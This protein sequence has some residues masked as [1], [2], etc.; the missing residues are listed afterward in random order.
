MARAA[1]VLVCLLQFAS[2]LIIDRRYEKESAA[3]ISG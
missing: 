3:T 1:M 2:S